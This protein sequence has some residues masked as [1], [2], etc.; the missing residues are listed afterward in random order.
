[1]ISTPC[2]IKYDTWRKRAEGTVDKLLQTI[3]PS[4]I[5]D[6]SL[7]QTI[8]ILLNLVE[9][10]N[11]DKNLTQENQRLRDENNQLKGGKPDIK[12]KQPRGEKSNLS[13]RERKTKKPWERV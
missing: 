6:E 10:L 3:D 13:S 11:S 1:L 5:A 2:V 4:E 8:E 12:A 7:R 9:Q